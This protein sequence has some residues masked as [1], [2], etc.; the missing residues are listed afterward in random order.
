MTSNTHLKS[1]LSDDSSFG[2]SEAE[3]LMTQ[4]M[5]GALSP[6]QVGAF[7][8]AL[9]LR[10]LDRDAGVVAAVARAM[11]GAASRVTIVRGDPVVD[12]VGTGGDGQD[13]FNVST[14]SAIVVAGAGVRVAKH[15]NRSS[16]S[17][18]GSADVLEALGAKLE[19][20]TADRVPL[21]LDASKFCFLFAQTFHTS[22][23]HV[24]GPR[25]ELGVK[26]IFNILGPLTNP[27]MPD[28][29]IVGV[30]SRDIGMVIADALRLSG[31]QRA[32]IVHGAIGLDEIAPIGET[33]VWSLENNAITESTIHPRDFGI[34]EHPLESVKG[35][36][37][38]YNSD[39]MKQLLA[40]KLADGHPVMDFVLL[41]SAA[42]LHVSGKAKT[43]K[44]GVELARASIRGGAAQA[45]LNAYVAASLKK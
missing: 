31:V 6:A 41:N 40:G 19:N 5:S 39:S 45:A 23:R 26:T 32:W 27:A 11:R 34:A 25:K 28:R 38:D 22:M 21:I 16:S 18:C 36:D 33:Y 1:L 10:G 12:I 30:F 42:L 7:L 17:K 13:T 35:G 44:E 29:M 4:I 3:T 14:A 2:A 8:T 20:V 9:K 37:S 15:G 43:L 24:A